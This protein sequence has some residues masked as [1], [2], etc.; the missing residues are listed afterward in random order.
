MH[1]VSSGTAFMLELQRI[2]ISYNTFAS[3]TFFGQNQ[4]FCKHLKM[5][6]NDAINCEQTGVELFLCSA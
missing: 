3:F 6:T 2:K 1:Y 4:C 5:V